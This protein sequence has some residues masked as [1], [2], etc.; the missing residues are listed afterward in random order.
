MQE[1]GVW[2]YL[3][4]TI[5]QSGMIGKL[6]AVNLG[7]AILVGGIYVVGALFKI[8]YPSPI[9]GLTYQLGDIFVNYLAAPVD[10]SELIYKPWSLISQLFA[11]GGFLHLLFNMI[12]LFFAGRMFVQFFGGKRLLTTYLAGGVF[13]YFVH[14]IAFY[15]FPLFAGENAT[16]IL[17]AS[18]AIYAIFTAIVIHR[19]TL[20]V[21]LFLI[22]IN[23]PIFLVFVLFIFTDLAGL[24]QAESGVSAEHQTAYF[25]HIGG[26][27]F[28]ALSIIN[29]NSP[30]SFMNRLERFF[31]KLKWPSFKRKPKMKIH[32]GGSARTMTDDEYNAASKDHQDRIDTILDKIS[33]KGYEGL[34]QEEKDILFNES[35]RKK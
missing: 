35:K 11:H 32:E 4:R 21:Q 9:P 20:K 29:I 2:A 14:V 26:A 24:V 22:P 18:G 8:N 27:I 33:K 25:A 23:I 6:I 28:G 17:G 7:V 3:K 15:S 34:T 31:S 19:P 13:A 1:E 16:S 10:P 30:K 5:Q 12:I